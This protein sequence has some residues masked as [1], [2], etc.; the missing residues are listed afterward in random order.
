MHQVAPLEAV[1][2]TVAENDRLTEPPP[3][4]NV[5]AALPSAVWETGPV[6]G[7]DSVMLAVGAGGVGGG[8]GVGVGSG[9]RLQFAAIKS[10]NERADRMCKSLCPI[11]K[12]ISRICVKILI[13][14][15][16]AKY[17]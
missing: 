11:I 10:S 13:M 17:P 9:S 5:A 16:I 6:E 12:I 2:A 4:S 1:H 8:V 7:I 14:C 15:I 3:A